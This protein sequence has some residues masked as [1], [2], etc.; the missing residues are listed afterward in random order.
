MIR[1]FLSSLLGSLNRGKG[2]ALFVIYH[3]GRAWCEATIMCAHSSVCVEVG[4]GLAM[5]WWNSFPLIGIGR[6][7]F[8]ISLQAY[9]NLLKG[10]LDGLKKRD[11]KTA[12][13]AAVKARKAKA[14]E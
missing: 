12:K 9:A 3:V 7:M 5:W 13:A 1:L 6:L 10:N 8:L 4:V 11:K 2:R 14:V